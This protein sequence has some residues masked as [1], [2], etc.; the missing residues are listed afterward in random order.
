MSVRVR[1]RGYS[2]D[3]RVDAVPPQPIRSVRRN[4]TVQ[5]DHLALFRHPD[6]ANYV[7]E[8]VAL[9]SRIDSELGAILA[10]MLKGDVRSSVAMYSALTSSQAQMAALEAAAGVSLPPDDLKLFGAVIKLIKRAGAKRNK[11]A[12]WLWAVGR[13][14]RDCRRSSSRR[15]RD[16][17][18]AACTYERIRTSD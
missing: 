2:I 7:A 9:W 12:H 10:Y 3:T 4:A 6:L 17:I 1:F 5:L 13:V 11:L 18:T 8:I 16:N 14:T 15:S